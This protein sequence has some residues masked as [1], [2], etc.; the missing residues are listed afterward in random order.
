M[1]K[2]ILMRHAKS[3]WDDTSLSDHDR[4]L[5]KRGLQDAPTMAQRLSE[6]G[7]NADLMISS[8]AL[9]AK[10]TAKFVARELGYPLE[11]IVFERSLF[12]AVPRSILKYLRAQNDGYQTILIFGHNPGFT[13]LVNCLGGEIE[14]LPTS[15]QFGFK[16]TSDRWAELS[17]ETAEVWFYDYPKK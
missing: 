10:E 17:S 6:R 14:N 5:A 13:D 1:K 2:L 7:I 8:S 15:G 16:L 3:A 9:R 12:H 11:K 4:P